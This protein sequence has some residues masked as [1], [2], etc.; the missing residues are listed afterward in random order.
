MFCALKIT[1]NNFLK[2]I[3]ERLPL[4]IH[5]LVDKTI[6]EVEKRYI[7]GTFF[8]FLFILLW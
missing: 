2:T 4:E 3:K 1:T 7:E 8:F 5:T 6:A